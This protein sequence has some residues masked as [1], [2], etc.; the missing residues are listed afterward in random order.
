MDIGGKA[1]EPPDTA[2]LQ[3]G[4]PNVWVKAVVWYT[5]TS[6]WIPTDVLVDS[7]A[8]GDTYMP[9]AFLKVVGN[10]ERGGASISIPVGSGLL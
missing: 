4:T 6:C 9:G 2:F 5:R 7:G 1:A 8:E 10:T 3:P